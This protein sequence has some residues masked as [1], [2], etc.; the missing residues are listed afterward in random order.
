M[1]AKDR[2]KLMCAI[3][4]DV[5]LFRSLGL[6]DY[7]LLIVIERK[8]LLKVDKRFPYSINQIEQDDLDNLNA[9]IL[10]L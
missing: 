7:S 1:S 3:K 4:K 10:Y 5:E 6:M 9:S 2:K 8:S